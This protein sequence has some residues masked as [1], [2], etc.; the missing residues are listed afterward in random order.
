MLSQAYVIAH[1]GKPQGDLTGF[2]KKDTHSTGVGRPYWGMVGRIENC[3]AGI[4]VA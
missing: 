2:L 3:P 4:F 1:L